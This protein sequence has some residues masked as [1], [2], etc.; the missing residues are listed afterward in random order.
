M[1]E[2]DRRRFA[3]VGGWRQFQRNAIPEPLTP[4][5]GSEQE[6]ILAAIREHVAASCPRC[7]AQAQGAQEIHHRDGNPRNNDLSNLELRETE[8]SGQ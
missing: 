5:V 4:P 1:S 6:R 8:G 7:K 3:E 2:E